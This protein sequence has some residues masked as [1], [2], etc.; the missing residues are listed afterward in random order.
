MPTLLETVAGYLQSEDWG[1]ETDLEN[2][3]LRG[4]VNGDNATL[5]W[6]VG[7]IETEDINSVRAFAKLPINIL[8]A[9]R[10]AIAELLIRINSRVGNG[11][12]ELDFEDGVV[13][14]GIVLD[15]MDGTLTQTMFMRMFMLSLQACDYY[16]PTI[17]GVI[18]GGT[19]PELALEML[20][21]GGEVRQ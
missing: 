16:F 10:P 19:A 6:Y 9:R 8:E 12:F 14:C 1:F 3:V 11:N 15:I 5:S 2:G 7:V 21:G 17:M 13:R 20:D 18:Y 4:S